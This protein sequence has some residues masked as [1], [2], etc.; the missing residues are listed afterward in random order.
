MWF[1][2]ALLAFSLA[3]AVLR[4][5]HRP[6]AERR[7]SEAQVIAAAAVLIAVTAFVAWQWWPLDDGSA[8]LALRLG[9]WPQGAVLF[10][11]G[12]WAGEAGRF[13]DLTA[14]GPR[15]GWTALAATALVAALLGYENARGNL[16]QILDGAGWPTMLLTILYGVISVAYT[17]WFTAMVRSR[18]SGDGPLRARAGQ[19]SYTAYFLHPLVLTAIMAMFASL[20]LAPELK[21]LIVA[22]VAVPACFL[23]GY[24]LTRLPGISRALLT[25]S[26]PAAQAG[27]RAATEPPLDDKTI[28]SGGPA[29][30]RTVLLAPRTGG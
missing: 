13:D 22:V 4:R 14:W 18:L 10:A 17:V 1:V 19:A 27:R 6:A 21:F 26:G 8:F 5:A 23:V 30:P 29:K 25:A 7:R 12:A 16:G 9:E 24:A 20:A 15:L 2:A 28:S 11:L 3:Y